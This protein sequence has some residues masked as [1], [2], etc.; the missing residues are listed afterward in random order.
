MSG[1]FLG[2]PFPEC[3]V[4]K[5]GR[6]GLKHEFGGGGRRGQRHETCQNSNFFMSSFQLYFL[7]ISFYRGREL[8]IILSPTTSME[9][10]NSQIFQVTELRFEGIELGIFLS[11]R[12]SIEVIFHMKRL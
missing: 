11:P 6:G 12:A 1:H 9:G 4:I 10:E 2:R 7:T 8:E 3:D 5:A